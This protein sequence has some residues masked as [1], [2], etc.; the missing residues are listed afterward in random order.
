MTPRRVRS[1]LSA[2]AAECWACPWNTSGKNAQGNAARH[3]RAT[4]HDV[5]ARLEYSV[6][7]DEPGPDA[8]APAGRRIL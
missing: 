7:P 5:T 8:R 3:V 1:R 4:G 6:G 2:G